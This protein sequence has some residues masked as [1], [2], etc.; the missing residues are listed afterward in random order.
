MGD[1]GAE[2]DVVP[3]EGH[4]QNPKRWPTSLDVLQ[5]CDQV[6][7]DGNAAGLEAD[8]DQLVDAVVALDDLMG[9]AAYSATHVVSG[10]DSCVGNENAPERGRHP[11]LAFGHGP[12]SS[13]RTSLTGPA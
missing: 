6:L 11:P 3:V 8:D 4:V 2:A 9:H 7:G 12:V 5:G 1:H 13:I 10:H